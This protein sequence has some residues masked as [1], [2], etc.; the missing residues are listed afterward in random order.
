MILCETYAFPRLKKRIF[1]QAIDV[2]IQD[3]AINSSSVGVTSKNLL[4]TIK[5]RRAAI[6]LNSNSGGELHSLR[7][8]LVNE[9][10]LKIFVDFQK[11]QKLFQKKKKQ[12]LF[13]KR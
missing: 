8:L 11:R 5:V 4:P 12:K 13:R 7:V 1:L 2:R 9:F 3:K 10:E 6:H